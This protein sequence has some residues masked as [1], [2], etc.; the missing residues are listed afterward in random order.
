MAYGII[1]EFP[2][3]TGQ[4]EY[5]AVNAKLGIDITNPGPDWPKGMISHAAGNATGGGLCVFE[6]WESKADQ[7][8][9]MA[10]SLGGA[11]AE[12]QVPPPARV[13]ELDLLNHQTV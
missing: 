7:E 3:G 13:T 6:I 4:K 8:A 2:A 9:F 1:L 11:L 5:D 10:G 12:V